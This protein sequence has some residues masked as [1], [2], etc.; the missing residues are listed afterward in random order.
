MLSSTNPQQRN[1]LVPHTKQGFRLVRAAPI[2]ER[3]IS[4]S[5]LFI[6]SQCLTDF[7]GIMCE[8]E[9]NDVEFIFCGL[10]SLGQLSSN[11]SEHVIHAHQVKMGEITF[12]LTQDITNFLTTCS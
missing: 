5:P 10:G 2:E 3:N 8:G 6:T 4:L 12:C 11:L 1:P 7:L 9:I